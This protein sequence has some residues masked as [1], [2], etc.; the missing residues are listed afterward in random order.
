MITVAICTYNRSEILNIVLE[1][2]S[3]IE[4]FDLCE[5]LIINNNSSDDTE[6]TIKRFSRKFKNVRYV[7]EK[8]QGLSFARNRAISEMTKEYLFFLDDDALPSMDLIV[9][10]LNI[11]NQNPNV[12]VLGGIYTPWYYY[13]R[14]KWFLDVYASKSFSKSGLFTL[15]PPE[16]LSGGIMLFHK[17]VFELCGKFDPNLGMMKDTIHYGEESDLQ[18]RIRKKGIQIYGND[19]LLIEHIVQDYKLKLAWFFKQKR[20]MGRSL[21]IMNKNSKLLEFIKGVL[22]AI[23]QIIIFPIRNIPRLIRKRYYFQNFIIDSYSKPW[24]WLNYSI[25]ILYS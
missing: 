16:E 1:R 15:N 22:I 12:K 9:K 2:L 11:L 21:A 14:P 20:A 18:N 10:V 8:E 19:E 23:L 24:K 5:V 25:N 6:D 17:S 4:K 7:F 13:G 3:S